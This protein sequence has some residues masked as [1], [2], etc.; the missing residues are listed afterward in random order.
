MMLF[1]VT[2]A[3]AIVPVI[4]VSLVPASRTVVVVVVVVCD[5]LHSGSIHTRVNVSLLRRLLCRI[6]CRLSGNV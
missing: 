1:V 2:E 6:G 3:D 5:T 4:T